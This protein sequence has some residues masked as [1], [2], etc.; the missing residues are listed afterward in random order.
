[1]NCFGELYAKYYDLL[2]RDKDYN[3]EVEYITNLIK[4]HK[5]EA[6]TILDIGCGTG[7]HAALIAD[8]GY[9]VH[10][11]DISEE[12]LLIAETQCNKERKLSFSQADLT[13]LNLNKKFDVVTALFHVISYQDTD[14]KLIKAFESVK[15]HLN[16]GGIFLFDFWYG[17]AVL[18]DPPAVRVKRL[19]NEDIKLTRIAEPKLYSENNLV[20]VKYDVWLTEKNN[21]LINNFQETHM[22]RYF[23]DSELKLILKNEGLKKCSKFAWMT[24]LRPTCESWYALWLIEN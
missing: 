19:E 16:P 2:Y 18:S 20:E 15:K 10:G 14:E 11:V 4:E 21:S 12:M 5:P 22:L 17:P 7:R 23:F 9:E 3:A 8:N 13:C 6:K 1:M 24:S